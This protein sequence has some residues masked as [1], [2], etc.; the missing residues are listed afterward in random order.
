ML[1]L[2]IFLFMGVLMSLVASALLPIEVG[3]TMK[4]LLNYCPNA[5]TFLLTCCE[6]TA[7]SLRT[8]YP[9]S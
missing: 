2:G 5:T 1:Y 7:E 3:M 6:I 8:H 4:T 9:L